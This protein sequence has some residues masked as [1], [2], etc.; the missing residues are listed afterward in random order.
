[1]KQTQACTISSIPSNDSAQVKYFTIGNML[2]E[3]DAN[4]SNQSSPVLRPQNSNS[5]YCGSPSSSHYEMSNLSEE[6]YY[7]V[8]MKLRQKLQ[9]VTC[10]QF[11]NKCNQLEATIL[12]EKSAIQFNQYEQQ[13]LF[14]EFQAKKPQFSQTLERYFT[15]RNQAS[16][17]NYLDQ[18]S[19]DS[20]MSSINPT[21]QKLQQDTKENIFYQFCNQEITKLNDLN[22]QQQF[23]SYTVVQ[24]LEDELTPYIYKMGFS[25]SFIS[26]LGSSR[27]NFQQM[28]MRSGSYL[29]FHQEVRLRYNMSIIESLLICHDKIHENKN[30]HCYTEN[31]Q[32]ETFERLFFNCVINKYVIPCVYGGAL[33][34]FIVLDLY[35]IPNQVIK[36][37][38]SRRKQANCQ[39]VP[40][41]PEEYIQKTEVFLQK[42][43]R[44]SS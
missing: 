19:S 37:L 31:C 27:N 38:L 41:F 9:P 26:I 2:F 5:F 11:N 17:F 32:L 22:G 1:M 34:G 23:F 14:Y 20:C 33:L 8:L 24:C 18:S 42:I 7:Q 36:G 15:L 39:L 12:Q 3:V 4:N 35:T 28:L 13:E 43:K 25:E 40:I 29:P 44:Y 16:S 10:I 21:Q 6:G 30:F